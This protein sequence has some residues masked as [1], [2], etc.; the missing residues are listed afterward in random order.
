L[1]LSFEANSGQVDQRVKVLSRGNGYSLFLAGDEAVV[2]LK[3][4]GYGETVAAKG[5][6][7]LAVNTSEDAAVNTTGCNLSVPT[8]TAASSVLTNFRKVNYL[9]GNNPSNWRTNI[10]TYAKVKYEGVYP[11]VDL[12]YYGN[13]GQLE[14]DFVV[15]PGTPPDSIGLH[16]QANK[17]VTIDGNG[18]L[19]PQVENV[20]FQKPRIYQQ[21]GTGNKESTADMN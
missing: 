14:Y 11:G 20:R 3:K 6:A 5:V 15:S 8:Q 19:I 17:K 21:L 18:D 2:V 9:I 7:G 4:S 13:Q 1:P 16:F 12:V 10:S